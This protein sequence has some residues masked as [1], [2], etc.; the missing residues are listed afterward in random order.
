MN[1]KCGES[2]TIIR[3]GDEMRYFGTVQKYN[4]SSLVQYDS[5]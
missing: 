4:E 2:V 5:E 3:N 1:K